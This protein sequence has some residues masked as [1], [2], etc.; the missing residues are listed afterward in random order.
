MHRPAHAPPSAAALLEDRQDEVVRRWLER[1]RRQPGRDDLSPPELLDRMPEFLRET[2][3]ALR[4]PADAP[5]LADLARE[6]GDQRWR[7]GADIDAVV[8]EYGLL[9]EVLFDLL[10]ESGARVSL[11]DVRVIGR[12]LHTG[13]A[14]AVARFAAAR[15]Q[16]LR[17][18][19]AELQAIL[20]HAPAA[21]YVEDLDGRLVLANHE[22]AALLGRPREALLG[23]FDDDRLPPAHA[24][25]T[26]ADHRR[27]L[28]T[29][30]PTLA[31][32]V[33]PR[34]DGPRTYLSLRFPLL[35]DAGR[36]Y[37]VCGISQDITERKALEL[38][39]ETALA[40]LDAVFTAAPVGIGLVDLELRYVRVNAALA[41]FHRVPADVHLGRRIGEI[42]P[43]DLGARL[44]AVI[45]R[46][47]HDRAPVRDLAFWATSPAEPTRA[48]HWLGNYFP[49]VAPDGAVLGVAGVVVELTEQTRLAA[50]RARAL[51]ALEHGDAFLLLDRDFRIVLVNHNQERLSRKPRET[52]L[53]RLFWDVWPE[54][55]SPDL[56]YWSHY[57]RCMTERVPVA[58][59]EYFAPLDLW[60]EVTAYP[61][62]EGGIAVFFRDVS[63]RKR[64]EQALRDRQ[65][66]LDRVFALSPD[67]LCIAG[68]DG[69]FRRVN[70]AFTAVLGHAESTLLATPY[71]ELIHPDDHAATRHEL[72]RL[73]RGEPTWHFPCRFRRADGTY[74][75]I[76]WR[77]SPDPGSQ[78][79]IAAGRD[80]T[81]EKARSDFER[82]LIGIVSHDL[83][84]PL[85]AILTSA[86]LALRRAAPDEATT[87]AL[88][89]IRASAERATRLI[90]DLLDLTHV[91]VEGTLPVRL[92][93]VNLRALVQEAVEEAERAFPGRTIRCDVTGPVTG[94]W[95]P[96]RLAQVLSNLLTNA[97]KF[98]PAET[99]V[100]LRLRGTSEDVALAVHNRGAP[101]PAARLPTIF[102]AFERG[103]PGPT[104]RASLGLG[105][106]IARQIVLAHAGRLAVT[107]TA[108]AGT[109]FTVQ[110]PRVA[111]RK[112]S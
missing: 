11:A 38:I 83:R 110:L 82:Q 16:A 55:A 12:A 85:A 63:A 91:R 69:R 10:E 80:I 23:A 43:D 92:R 56:K 25:L 54:T 28:T 98:S 84:N 13:V 88:T 96:D 67:L 95:D 109:T 57:H 72:G 112:D 73:A 36:P 1:V 15:E 22:T 111:V 94:C 102:E 99:A 35:D 68:L 44:E 51:D 60:T 61:A 62:H 100:E 101:I 17:S 65:W 18:S 108:E 59:E 53:G 3:T 5:R 47:L 86:T 77:A 71:L 40:E 24:A 89:R 6:H 21:I 105:L 49:V 39:R 97:L 41:A 90:E 30:Q 9:G 52:S 76:S 2:I 20:D 37:A 79:F 78:W 81:E 107:S 75:W 93:P 48:R 8:R 19:Q 26:R 45:R 46:V 42:L 50:E 29:L 103:D 32:E 34:E 66:E 106:H 58:F 31:E 4:R 70:P 33:V 87:R 27:A 7:T 74:R 14:E 104:S 64:A